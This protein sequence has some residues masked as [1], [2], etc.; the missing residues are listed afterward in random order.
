MEKVIIDYVIS[1]LDACEITKLRTR[2]ECLLDVLEAAPDYTD[3]EIIGAVCRMKEED[4][5]CRR[6][7]RVE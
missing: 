3:D 2:L 4:K 7:S 6:L 1:M 5:P